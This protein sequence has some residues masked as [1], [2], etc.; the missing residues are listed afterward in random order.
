MSSRAPWRRR[1]KNGLAL[2][3]GDPDPLSYRLPSLSAD[4]PI[5]QSAAIRSPYV[6]RTPGLVRVAVS[7]AAPGTDGLDDAHALTSEYS[8]ADLLR[9]ERFAAAPFLEYIIPPDI[10]APGWRSRSVLPLLELAPSSP[11]PS[12][13]GADR[14]VE[15]RPPTENGQPCAWQVPIGPRRVP[16]RPVTDL[17]SLPAEVQV[18]INVK[19]RE[20]AVGLVD[21]SFCPLPAA[22]PPVATFTTAKERR[23]M[24]PAPLPS[25]DIRSGDRLVRATERLTLSQTATAVEPLLS[26]QPVS[27]DALSPTRRLIHGALGIPRSRKDPSAP[28]VIAASPS[29]P[30]GKAISKAVPLLTPETSPEATARRPSAESRTS[31]RLDLKPEP[32][33]R[34]VTKIEVRQHCQLVLALCAEH[35]ARSAT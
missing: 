34:E 21:E 31:G 13:P 17:A 32:F 23:A 33:I 14:S 5:V 1:L 35:F 16:G 18:G 22:S 20:V 19:R 28:E 8:R 27:K 29:T 4:R 26:A 6:I 3:R 9:L 11:P 2:S 30:V 15:S 24:P 25:G 10:Y 12:S 7:R